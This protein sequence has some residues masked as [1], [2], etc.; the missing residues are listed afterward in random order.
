MSS[1]GKL[2]KQATRMQQQ[3]E[4]VQQELA[5]KTVEGVAGGGTVKVTAR[6]DQSLVSIKIAPEA[7][8]PSDVAFLEEL[9]LTATNQALAAAKETANKEMG[10]VTQGMSIPGLF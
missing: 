9:I 1:I 4:R 3:M 2:M 8:N 7:V 6:C 10:S 5:K